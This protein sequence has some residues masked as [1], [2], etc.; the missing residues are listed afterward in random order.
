MKEDVLKEDILGK[1]D[2]AISYAKNIKIQP[3]IARS[4]ANMDLLIKGLI[5][6]EKDVKEY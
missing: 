3:D 6:I 4:E 2:W 1:L 5:D